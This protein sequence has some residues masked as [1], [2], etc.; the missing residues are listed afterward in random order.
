M[1]ATRRVLSP[2]LISAQ[3]AMLIAPQ[4]T[5][6]IFRSSFNTTKSLFA[7]EPTRQNFLETLDKNAINAR[8]LGQA[9]I[10]FWRILALYNDM[11]NPLF[12]PHGVDVSTFTEGAKLALDRFHEV[13]IS[14]H[15]SSHSL[16]QEADGNEKDKSLKEDTNGSSSVKTEQSD[17]D[18][19]KGELEAVLAAL[20]GNAGSELM[21][22]NLFEH[23]WAKEA[24]EDPESLAAELNNMVTPQYF[25][26]LEITSKTWLHLEKQSNYSA[27]IP[28]SIK[29]V[30]ALCQSGRS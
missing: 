20:G 12:K 22:L 10:G 7:S 15:R 2:S 25:R 21:D 1:N 29:N 9:N 30:S 14:L 5:W 26:M 18:A 24:E 6:D 17:D 13:Q 4:T 8:V 19:M 16:E 23:S 3:K 27:D 28:S 11:N